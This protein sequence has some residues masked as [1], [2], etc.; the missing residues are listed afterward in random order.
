LLKLAEL[1]M[2]LSC[3][4][5]KGKAAGV[6]LIHA[7]NITALGKAHCLLFTEVLEG[8]FAELLLYGVL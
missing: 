8:K 3:L 5:Q 2:N 7:S 1:P 4:E 6:V